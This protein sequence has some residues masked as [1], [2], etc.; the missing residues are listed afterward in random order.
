MRPK[1]GEPSRIRGHFMVLG[2][3][4][5]VWNCWKPSK[6]CVRASYNR[7]ASNGTPCLLSLDSIIYIPDLPIWPKMPT[8]Y[9]GR[10]LSVGVSEESYWENREWRD[11]V[12]TGLLTRFMIATWLARTYYV[13]G[14]YLLRSSNYLLR[15]TVKSHLIGV[16]LKWSDWTIIDHFLIKYSLFT[17]ELSHLIGE[18]HEKSQSHG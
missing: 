7:Q 16:T 8:A 11:V 10:F 4:T 5:N 9:G 12:I 14:T 3:A 18:K 6:Q 17:Y 15:S 13:V 1:K 2:V